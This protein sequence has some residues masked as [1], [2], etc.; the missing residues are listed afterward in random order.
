MVSVALHIGILIVAAAAWQ[1]KARLEEPAPPRVRVTLFSRP[2]LPAARPPAAP[3]APRPAAA[4]PRALPPPRPV[5]FE[6]ESKPLPKP[7]PVSAAAEPAQ[8]DAGATAVA[9]EPAGES[10]G[11]EGPRALGSSADAVGS[12]GAPAAGVAAPPPPGVSSERRKLV[13]DRYL[14]EIFRSRI[15]AKFHYPE[16][17][18]RLGM[19]GLVVVRVAVMATGALWSARIVGDCSQRIL[20][21]AAE[22]TVRDAAPFPPPPAELGGAISVDVPLQY[23]LE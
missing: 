6:Q 5:P 8:P 13:L 22:R 17:A 11:N 1:R 3:P 23:R 20:C 12:R 4:P 16:A 10:A 14:Q 7:E 9:L 21:A 2:Q 15:A 19:E 18:E